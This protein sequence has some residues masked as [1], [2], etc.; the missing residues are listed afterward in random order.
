[1]NILITGGCS[2]SECESPW[3]STWPQ[4]LANALPRYQHISTGLS[5]QGNG[6]I[7]RQVIYQVTESLK[8]TSADN[9]IVGIMW[10]GPDRH[11]FYVQHMS[12][13]PET[14][15]ITKFV[16]GGWGGWAITNHQ[17]TTD[18]SK[19][20]YSKF[21]TY[22]GALIYTLEHILRTQWFLK[23]HG[24]KYFMSTYTGEVLPDVTKTHHDMQ[25]LYNLIDTSVF[26][27]VVGEYEWCRDHSGLEFPVPDDN[28]P[29]TNQHQLFVEQVVLPFLK[30]RNS[31]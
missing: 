11:D 13:M 9:I 26:L 29:S 2:F 4:H 8:Q 17:W 6:L 21:H 28:H 22:H 24:I 31:I 7:S 3:I 20:Y 25:H 1:M 23:S 15:Y 30:E 5:S 16:K 10:S 18:Y 12:E 14:E 19:L 27:P